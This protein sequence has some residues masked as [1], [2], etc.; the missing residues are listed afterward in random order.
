MS[1]VYSLTCS[2][3][4]SDVIKDVAPVDGEPVVKSGVDKF[5]GTDLEKILREEGIKTVILV[6]TSAHGAVLH[7]AT[8]AA[9]RGLQVIVAVDGVSAGKPYAE[10]CTAWHLVNAPGSRRQVTLTRTDLIQFAEESQD[11]V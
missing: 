5:F 4:A 11:C 8:G 6:G 2:A 1:V 7:T 10:Q 3:S 9:L